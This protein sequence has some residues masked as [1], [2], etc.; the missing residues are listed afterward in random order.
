MYGS[1]PQKNEI[2]DENLSVMRIVYR[3]CS[4]DFQSR[5]TA[6]SITLG[7][8][9]LIHTHFAGLCI[10]LSC[11]VHAIVYGSDLQHTHRYILSYLTCN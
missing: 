5:D 11:L 7:A 10:W 8:I 6:P 2:S 4:G 3:N 1:L 9:I